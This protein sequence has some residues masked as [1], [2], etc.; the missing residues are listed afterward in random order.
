MFWF[1]KGSQSASYVIL[2]FELL[3]QPSLWH[4]IVHSNVAK[5]LSRRRWENHFW[6]ARSWSVFS[7]SVVAKFRNNIPELFCLVLY[8]HGNK[9]KPKI[10]NA[11]S[12]TWWTVLTKKLNL[13]IYCCYLL[14]LSFFSS[15]RT[16]WEVY[17]DFDFKIIT[18]CDV[19]NNIG[20]KYWLP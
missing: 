7:F 13:T 14:C 6:L 1:P 2:C 3:V 4:N 17:M 15:K 11:Y 16:L 8:R 20:C 19:L 10:K 12:L 5:Q 18:Q 9:R